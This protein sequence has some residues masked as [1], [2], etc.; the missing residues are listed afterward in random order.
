MP[1]SRPRILVAYYS[2]SGGTAA[3][4]RR[5]AEHWSG[6]V[7]I[8]EIF[9]RADRRGV[10]GWLRCAVDGVAARKATILTSYNDVASYD[11]VIVGTPVWASAVS[12]PVRTYLANAR[13]KTR[14]IAFFLTHG[15][16]GSERAFAQMEAEVQQRPEATLA[17]TEQ[18]IAEGTHKSRAHEFAAQLQAGV[19][20]AG[21]LRDWQADAPSEG[22]VSLRHVPIRH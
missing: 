10:L 11:L 22:H 15:G 3:V 19:Q 8:E 16:S 5:I 12:S 4:A 1:T 7:D 18:E 9:D 21:P 2:R 20:A 13:G 17:V 6:N 14:R